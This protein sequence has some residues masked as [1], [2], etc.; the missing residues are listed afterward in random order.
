ME[1]PRIRPLAICVCRDGDR[2]LVAEGFDSVKREAFL[3]PLGGS[4]EFGERGA[5]AVAREFREELGADVARI[6]YLGVIENL[7]TC[8]G[9]PGH[10]I[11]LVY[12]GELLDRSLYG[13]DFLEGIEDG[14]TPFRAVWK[15][16][17]ELREGSIPVY[18]EGLLDLLSGG[19]SPC[20]G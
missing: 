16:L 9:Q 2:I 17:A 20:A 15:P 18:P 14:R 4:I 1:P 12:D 3:R 8:E 7:F 19:G 13:K 10:E 5:Q 11:V 6:R